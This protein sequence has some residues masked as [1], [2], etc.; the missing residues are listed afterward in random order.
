MNED[1][2]KALFLF[3]FIQL[4]TSALR[5]ATKHHPNL[6]Y[7]NGYIVQKVYSDFILGAN[8][9]ALCEGQYSYT[10]T[11][12]D[13]CVNQLGSYIILSNVDISVDGFT[14]YISTSYEDATCT[15]SIIMR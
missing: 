10:A 12:V 15:N 3:I 14:S 5:S 11:A 2:F 8:E 7:D 4:T 1:M 13:Q 6:A 9:N